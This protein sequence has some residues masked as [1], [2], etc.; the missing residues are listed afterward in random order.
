MLSFQDAITRASDLPVSRLL[1]DFLRSCSSG[2]VSIISA[3]AGSGKTTLIPLACAELLEPGQRVLV[4]SP[5]RVSARSCA[6]RLAQLLD[7]RVGHLVGFSVRGQSERSTSTR[8]EFVTPGVLTR[9]IHSDPE[10]QGIGCVIL[11][12]FHER[13]VDSD[14]ACA[15]LS[16]IREVL[17]E[18]LRL[19]VMSATVDIEALRS[20][21]ADFSPQ[22]FE[23]NQEL[24]PVDIVWEAPPRGVD[25]FQ[26]ER[27]ST[28]FLRHIAVLA[29]RALDRYPGDALVFVPGMREIS[30]VC[31]FLE[32]VDAQVIALHG[33]LSP[34]QQDEIFAA[35]S[36]RRIIVS[37]SIAESALTVPGVQIVIDSTLSRHTRFSPAREAT[38]LV[39]VPSPRSSMVQRAGRAGRLGPGACIRAMESSGWAMRPSQPSP[40]IT[41]CDPVP[42][43]LSVACW[44]RADFSSVRL[45]DSP[46]RGLEEYARS[47]LEALGAIDEAGQALPHGRS[48]ALSP[49]DPRIAHALSTLEDE[50][51][52]EIAALCAAVLSEDLRP[53]GGDLLSCLYSLPLGGVQ[54]ARIEE[55]AARMCQ[56]PRPIWDTHSRAKVAAAMADFISHAFPL[57]LARQREGSNRYLLVSGVGASLPQASALEGSTWLAI[58]DLQSTTGDGIIR[59]A[60]PLDQDTACTAASHI[61]KSVSRLTLDQGRIL[62]VIEEKL[63]AVTLR[64]TRDLNPNREAMRSFALAELAK[65]SVAD[66]P[67][68]QSASQL[69]LRILKC[70]EFLGDPWPLVDDEHFIISCGQFLADQ[71]SDGRPLA[72]LS[73]GEALTS[74]LV[75]PLNRDLDRQ[76]P[77][78]ITIPT[79]AERRVEWDHEGARVSLRVQEAFGWTETPRFMDGRLPLRI[80]LTDPAGR[81]VAITSDLESFWKGP[82]QQVRSELRGRYTKHHWPEDPFSVAPT[83]RTKRAS[84]RLK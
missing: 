25:Y 81:P 50:I 34:S 75:W 47:S 9:M 67:W 10:L 35:S 69:R 26:G 6:R 52:R 73:L 45:L 78:Q 22:V 38:S 62:A 84:M 32:G 60:L 33:Q 65:M 40:E 29:A 18:D 5:R 57:R 83:A 1:P 56:S 80:E 27:V 70:R 48:L 30:K 19:V 74:L 17:R 15:F 21:L 72:D 44:A 28:P 58:A 11:D 43:L 59:S 4:C 3:S 13:A 8:I 14:L 7:D 79:G 16:D 39:T 42:P 55:T 63:G 71:W 2:S 36:S 41:I 12:E 54:A 64:S 61:H 51:P 53:K 24:Y 23:L 46:S 82:Y 49:V 77:T 68:S 66:L 20:L 76:A 37:S 31:E